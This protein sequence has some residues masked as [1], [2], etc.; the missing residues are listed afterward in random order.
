M[1]GTFVILPRSAKNHVANGH[2]NNITLH[3]VFIF[4]YL[5]WDG[6]GVLDLDTSIVTKPLDRYGCLCF[7]VGS[8]SL[9]H[10]S[11]LARLWQL[12]P[13]MMTLIDFPFIPA[14]VWKR[15][16]LWSSHCWGWAVNTLVTTSEGLA[17]WSHRSSWASIVAACSVIAT[18][19]KASYSPSLMECVSPFSSVSMTF[20][21]MHSNDLWPLPPHL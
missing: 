5:E 9:S 2:G 14:L 3:C 6:D 7:F 13:S 10:N 11:V 20:V 12:P 15:L 1:Y 16:H 21:L 8:W 19:C 4:A 18:C 17:S